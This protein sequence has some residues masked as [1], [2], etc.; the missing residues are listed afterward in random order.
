MA[1][2]SPREPGI[3]S[4]PG[5]L[6]RPKQKRP[7]GYNKGVNVGRDAGQTVMHCHVHLIPRYARDVMD[8]IGGLR[9]IIPG[10]GTYFPRNPR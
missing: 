1:A 3:F 9:S 2:G 4:V 8:P 6:F 10:K 7:G 5:T